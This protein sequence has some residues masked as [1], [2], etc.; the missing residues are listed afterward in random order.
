MKQYSKIYTDCFT[1]NVVSFCEY[2]F[3]PKLLLF[4]IPS[5]ICTACIWTN[6]RSIFAFVLCL[7]CMSKSINANAKQNNLLKR[8]IKNSV[9]FLRWS[10]LRWELVALCHQFSCKKFHLILVTTLCCG[11]QEPTK[12]H[13]SLKFAPLHYFLHKVNDILNFK[14][15][16]NTRCPFF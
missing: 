16:N 11:S 1:F 5:K 8:C 12:I 4:K 10:F 13:L 9:K 3:Y 14:N 7:I 15:K 6:Y 2:P